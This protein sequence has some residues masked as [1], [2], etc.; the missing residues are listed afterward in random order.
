L[1]SSTVEA[2]IR[3]AGEQGYGVFWMGFDPFAGFGEFA[4]NNVQHIAMSVCKCS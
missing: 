2:S 3:Q 1:A 4:E